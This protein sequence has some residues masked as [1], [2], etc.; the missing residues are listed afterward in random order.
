MYNSL[1]RSKC[2]KIS[3]VPHGDIGMSSDCSRIGRGL[4]RAAA[5]ISLFSVQRVT[6][7]YD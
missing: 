4:N 6:E 2:T 3:H 1:N 5:F 7:T